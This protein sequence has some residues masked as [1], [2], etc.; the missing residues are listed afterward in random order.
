M[1][2]IFKILRIIFIS[3]GFISIINSCSKENNEKNP[4][5]PILTTTSISVI[6]QISA[7]SGGII[8]DDGGAPIISRGVCWNTSNNSTINDNKTTDG[9]GTGTFFSSMTGL[10]D[11]TTYYVKAYA[12]NSVGTA[13]GSELVFKTLHS[14]VFGSQITDI[15]GNVYKTVI[16]GTQTWMAENLR[17]TKFNDNT[18][19]LLLT[20]DADWEGVL[21]GSVYCW[22][23][24][25]IANKTLYGALYNW[26]SVN[27]GILCPS[28][29]HVPTDAEWT[30]LSDYLGGEKVVA[31]KLKEVGSTHWVS[32]NSDETDEYGFKALPGGMREFTGLFSFTKSDTYWWSTTEAYGL[33]AWFREIW[34]NNG[35][36]DFYH[37]FVKKQYGFSVRCVKN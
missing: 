8:T 32:P 13:Y 11:N 29:W 5:T 24:N 9:S 7:I 16:I 12:T 2:N 35:H 36:S 18:P 19:I 33:Y 34:N 10:K 17:T 1:K 3:T 26:S 37:D 4:T 28:G 22:Q 23:N 31:G 21:W 15:E 6:T 20:N 30:T 27:T 14:P 25:D